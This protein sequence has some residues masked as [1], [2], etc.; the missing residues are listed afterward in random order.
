M[1]RRHYDYKTGAPMESSYYRT[2]A[3]EHESYTGPV[4]HLRNEPTFEFPEIAP[5]Q[6]G[7]IYPANGALEQMWRRKA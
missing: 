7:W 5:W 2:V 4:I 3:E 1:E 6:G